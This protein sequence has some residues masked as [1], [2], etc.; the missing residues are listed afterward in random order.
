MARKPTHVFILAWN[1]EE[2]IIDYLRN[3]FGF[4]GTYI[5]PLPKEPRIVE[6]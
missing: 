3:D 5:V 1:F 2:E 4:K 6:S